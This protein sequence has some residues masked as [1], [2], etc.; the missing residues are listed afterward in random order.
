M[1]CDFPLFLAT[2]NASQGQTTPRV[3]MKI[4]KWLQKEQAVPSPRLL[5]MAFRSCGKSTLVGVFCA[6]ALAG[7]PDTRILV[8]SADLALARKMVRNVKRIIEKHP[9]TRHLKPE[10]LDQWGSEKFTVNREMEL[11]DPSMLAKGITTNLTGT[12]ADIII[13][14]DVEVP[15]T[16]DTFEKRMDLRERLTELDYI[17]TPDG[18]QLYVGTPH[19]WHTIYADAPRAELGEEICFLDGFQRLV[20]PVQTAEG[21]S[22]WPERFSVQKINDILKKTGPAHFTS[23]MLCQPMNSLDLRLDPSALQFY[24]DDISYREAQGK[25]ILSIDGRE[26]ASVAGW[27]DPAFGKAGGDRS[28]LAIVYTDKTGEYWLQHI[29]QI[30][31]DPASQKDEATQ[32]CEQVAE[33]AK[34]FFLTSIALETNGL[35]KFLPNILRRELGLSGATCSVREITSRKPKATR[36]MEA[37]DAPMAARAIHVHRSVLTTPFIKEMEDWRPEKRGGHDDCL[38]AVAGALSSQP[39]RIGTFPAENT[40]R[41]WVAIRPRTQ[42]KTDFDV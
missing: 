14:D 23:Q 6:W 16:S 26:L 33:I 17:L 22:V 40:A 13:C 41:Q 21:Q 38:D 24:D 18:M 2:W 11:R 34:R 29:A 27:W 39:V 10:K 30:K 12:R 15:K 32:Q 9:M 7:A 35:G 5:L 25:C 3:H 4:A 31:I 36:I 28:I 20:Q 19:C 1:I 8:L 37:F 42:A